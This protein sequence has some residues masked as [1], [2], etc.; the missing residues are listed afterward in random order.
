MNWLAFENVDAKNAYAV[1]IH[2]NAATS[3]DAYGY[4]I[5]AKL[6]SEPFAQSVDDAFRKYDDLFAP[7]N[8][9][10]KE[11]KFYINDWW[12]KSILVECGFLTNP[13]DARVL[14]EKY[15]RIAECIAHGIINHFKNATDNS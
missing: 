8:P 14:S 5:Y 4:E 7:R 1:S 3:P 6:G 12:A 15:D 2:C 11:S 9:S 10:V 13:G